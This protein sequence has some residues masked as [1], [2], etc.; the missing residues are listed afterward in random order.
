VAHSGEVAT[1]Q[2]ERFVVVVLGRCPVV[3]GQIRHGE[4]VSDT[5]HTFHDSTDA[6]AMKLVAETVDQ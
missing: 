2:V 1:P 3:H 4:P 5:W 6:V